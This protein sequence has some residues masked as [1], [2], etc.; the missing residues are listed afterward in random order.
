MRALGQQQ[1]IHRAQ[2][3]VTPSLE[4]D[5]LGQSFQALP[6]RI[7]FGGQC[8]S[9]GLGRN[10]WWVDKNWLRDVLAQL[11]SQSGGAWPP[12]LLLLPCQA[13]PRSYLH[14]EGPGA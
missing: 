11:F 9:G 7:S 5:N 4:N 12:G 14:E 6:Q 2:R 8:N 13:V 3:T 10:Y 1:M